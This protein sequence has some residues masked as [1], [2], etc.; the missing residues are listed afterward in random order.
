MPAAFSFP[1]L[2]P[3][4]GPLAQVRQPSPVLWACD[5]SWYRIDRVCTREGLRNAGCGRRRAMLFPLVLLLASAA[6]CTDDRALIN[7]AGPWLAGKGNAS[8]GGVQE[9]RPGVDTLLVGEEAQFSALDVSG[10][11][12][13]A[14]W[15]SDQELVATVSS[16]GLVTAVSGGTATITARTGGQRAT[17]IVTVTGSSQAVP[18]ARVTVSPASASLTVGSGIQLVAIVKDANGNSLTGRPVQWSS[19]NPSIASVDSTGYVAALAGGSAVVTAASEGQSGNSSI[20]VSAPTTGPVTNECSSAPAA[21]IWCDDFEQDRL[22]GYFEYVSNNGSFTRATGVG[23]GGSTGMRA[24]WSA[25]GQV[26]AGNLKLAFGRTPSSYMRPVDAGTQNYREVFWRVYVRNEP[27][28]TGG[29]GYKFSRAI[30]FANS[31]WAEAM[32]A[33]LWTGGTTSVLT[34]DPASGTDASGNL[35][36]TQYNDFANLRWLGSASGRTPIFDSSHVGQWYCVEAHV[37]LN[38]AGQ[39]NGVFEFWVDGNLE[40][41]RS[42][43]NWVGSYADYGIN[44]VFLENYWNDGA[45]KAQERYFDRFVVSTQPIGC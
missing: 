40:A 36:T 37:R 42:D 8:S 35:R 9:I 39:S 21:W 13:V 1:V 32:I 20:A 2:A 31:N 3:E 16:T 6:G 7:P 10:Q 18:V 11:T 34:I 27:A 43:L 19:S 23:V 24:R 33:H 44:S 38:D 29:G 30:S 28:W 22:S 14:K 26:S 4:R 25:A 12:I 45:P 15:S 17:A 5:M 41:R